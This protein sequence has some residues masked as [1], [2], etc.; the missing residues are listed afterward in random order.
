MTKEKA[1]KPNVNYYNLFATIIYGFAF[2]RNT[3]RD[4]EDACEFDL[5]YIYSMEQKKISYLTICNFIHKVIVPNE[6]G[7]FSLINI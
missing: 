4:L 7:I 2:G 1:E 3:L 5:R 6:K